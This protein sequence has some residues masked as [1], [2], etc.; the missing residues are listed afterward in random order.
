MLGAWC[1][2]PSHVC[3]GLLFD[4]LAAV[5]LCDGGGGRLTELLVPAVSDLSLHISGVVRGVLRE[6]EQ[7]HSHISLTV[8]LNY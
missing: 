3:C 2:H 1:S 6:R 4:R 8:P 5:L 7:L